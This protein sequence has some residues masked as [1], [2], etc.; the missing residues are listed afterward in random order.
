MA[1]ASPSQIPHPICFPLTRKPE[2]LGRSH[3]N[4]RSSGRSC[5]GLSADQVLVALSAVPALPSAQNYHQTSVVSD[6]KSLVKCMAAR[7]W[8]YAEPRVDRSR[9]MNRSRG[10]VFNTASAR[11]H[12]R[13]ALATPYDI[14]LNSET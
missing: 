4:E 3:G 5:G 13:R 2:G 11:A 1:L 14:L 8:I 10:R 7:C 12:P 6:T 9:A